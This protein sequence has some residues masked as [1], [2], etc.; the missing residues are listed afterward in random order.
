MKI[1]FENQTGSRRGGFTLVELLVVISIIAVLAALTLSVMGG[2]SKRQKISIAQAEMQQIETALENYKAKYGVYP[3]GNPTNALANQ[4]YYELTGVTN[5]VAGPATPNYE[6]LDGG[7]QLSGGDFPLIFGGVGGII[8]CSK[9]SGE[10]TVFAKNFLPGLKPSQVTTSTNGNSQGQLVPYLATSV[11]GPDVSYQ[12]GYAAGLGFEGNPF[13]YVYPGTNNPNSY[14]L[15]V[16][17]SINSTSS[18]TN[19]Y[20]ICNWS[21]QVQH[22]SPLP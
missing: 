10:D 13:R 6:T 5:T 8:N 7:Y 1:I 17:L 15:W 9:S 22:N 14:D 20:L 3:P 11:A 16:Q 21:Q 18:T 19:H 12:P 2:V 4:L